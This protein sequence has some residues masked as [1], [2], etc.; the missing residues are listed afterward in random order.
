[1]A[2]ID[3]QNQP[4]RRVRPAVAAVA[5]L[6]LVM[7]ACGGG[8][9]G[10]GNGEGGYTL[11]VAFAN[12]TDAPAELSLNDG[13][14]QTVESCKG[15]VYLFTMPDTDWVLAVNGETAIDSIEQNP[16]H[17]DNNDATARLWLHEDGS[18]ELENFAPGSNISA[19]AA[20]SI[21]T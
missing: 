17:F 10:G 8:G 5:L 16:L 13:E 4:T 21:C 20:L 9:G 14:P 7:T 11:R 19:P 18:V 12:E 6:G 1:M 3:G 15:G 2:N